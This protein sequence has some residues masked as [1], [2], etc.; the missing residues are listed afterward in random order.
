MAHKKAAGT[1]KN[2][3]D[4]NPK[5]LGI[6]INPGQMVSAGTVLA[7]QRGTHILAGQNVG[8]GS[9]RTL[10]AIV[11]GKLHLRETRRTHFNNKSKT[12]KIFDVIPQ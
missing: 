10:F 9:D 7:R 1:T 6:K 4:S 8:M 5:Y 11:A 12:K 3:R 2:G